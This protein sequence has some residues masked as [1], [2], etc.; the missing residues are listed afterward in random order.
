MSGNRSV[1]THYRTCNLCEAMCGIAIELDGSEIL[2][3]TGDKNDPLSRGYICPK[4][5]AL[6]DIYH[7][8][9]RLKQPLRRTSDGWQP[10]EWDAAFDEVAA[11]LLEIQRQH[12]RDAVAIYQGNP[13]VH[14]SG[15]MLFAPAFFRALGTRNRFSAT[16]VD[17]L[18]HHFASYFMFGHQLLI[19]VP[20]VDRTHFLLVLGANPLVSNGSLMTAPGMRRRLRELRQ[21]GGKLV[22]VDPRR[23][24]TAQVA[25]EH[26]FIRPGTDALFLLALLHT[27][28]EQDLVNLGPVADLCVGQER[29]EALV[30]EFAPE[31]VASRT[32]IEVEAIR[33]TAVAFASAPS[34]VCY[35]RVGV[36]TQ[37]YGAL[38]HWLINLLNALT[39]NL[40]RPGGA[41]FAA[42]AIETVDRRGAGHYCRYSSRVRGAPEFGG[43]LPV[44][45]L[46]EE[47]LTEGDGKIRALVTSAGNPVLSTPNGTQLERALSGLDFMV[48]IDIYLNETTRHADIILPPTTGLETDHYD[49]IFHTLAVHNTAKYSSALF[50]PAP[51]ARHDWQIFRQLRKRIEAAAPPKRLGSRLRQACLDRLGPE[52]L[53]DLGLR[54]GPYGVWRG[55][56]FSPRG[57]SL[58]K[59]R[60]HPQGIDLGPLRPCLPGRLF[61]ADGRVHLAPAVLVDDL[62]RLRAKSSPAVPFDPPLSLIGRRQLRSNNSW[63][64]NSLRLVKGKDACTL[65][66]HPADASVRSIRDG[67]TVEVSSRVGRINIAVELSTDMM[68]GVVSIPHGWGHGR[69]GVELQTAHAHAG[70]SINDLTDDQRVDTLCGNAAFSGEPVTVRG[71][72]TPAAPLVT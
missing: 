46:A 5:V 12:G 58:R 24:P 26:L 22:V 50:E 37:A 66:M 71:K 57:L 51:D 70:V 4:A 54:L 56:R 17:Q 2:T 69:P 52:R 38:C 27:L 44:S 67:E 3:I 62:Q 35:G 41:M 14:S 10:M 65:L 32:G 31:Q 6:Q 43:E 39:G 29:I 47:I 20:D 28:Y 25:D 9:D 21:R 60:R 1:R 63:M 64:H 33:R 55:R 18:P 11:R 13:T 7:D 45:T 48:S 30:A 42:P 72:R 15:T 19:P 61:T 49:L 36:S 8:P 40:D 68:P 16:S 34:A 53:L 59:L 23:T